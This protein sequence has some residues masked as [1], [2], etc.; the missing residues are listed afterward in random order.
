MKFGEGRDEGTSQFPGQDLL[1][2]D[3]GGTATSSCEQ[4]RSPAMATG[5]G[6]S[7]VDP[8]GDIILRGQYGKRKTT[9]S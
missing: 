2:A 3:F 9:T 6:H 7:H 4:G 8:S 1:G 5:G